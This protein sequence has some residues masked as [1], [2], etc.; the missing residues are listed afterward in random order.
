MAY[1]GKPAFTQFS[2]SNGGWTARGGFP[3]LPGKKDPFDDMYRNWAVTFSGNEIA[4]NWPG[5][6][7]F[8]RFEDIQRDGNG[9]WGGRVLTLDVVGENFTR[10]DVSM[11]TL[12]LWLGLRSTLFRN[13][14]VSGS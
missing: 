7:G 11:P 6:G 13:P 3:Y 1:Q 8:V 12:M 14:T 5:M 9:P 2:A 10:Q 4:R